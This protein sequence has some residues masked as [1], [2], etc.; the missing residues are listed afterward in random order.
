[1]NEKETEANA[2]LVNAAL[3]AMGSLMAIDHINGKSAIMFLARALKQNK[4]KS[5][6]V[7]YILE[8]EDAPEFNTSER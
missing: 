7:D 6:Y 2:N 4:I 5:C 1:M 8:K 3:Y